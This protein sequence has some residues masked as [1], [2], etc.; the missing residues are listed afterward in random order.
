MF[1]CVGCNLCIYDL[2][3]LKIL[4]RRSPE[5]SEVLLYWK[6]VA[7]AFIAAGFFQPA[8]AA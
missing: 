5:K 3:I 6:A 2:K 1:R 4:H 8:I 7:G